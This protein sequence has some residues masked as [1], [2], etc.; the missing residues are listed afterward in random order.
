MKLKKS[1][2]MLTVMLMSILAQFVS[3]IGTIQAFAETVDSEVITEQ[4]PGNLPDVKNTIN[5]AIAN[6]PIDETVLTSDNEDE[7]QTDETIEAETQSEEKKLEERAVEGGRDIT[8]MPNADQL[9][10][11][12]YGEPMILTD[13]DMTLNGK[14]I[15]A[16]D[17]L[18]IGDKFQINY[19]FRIPDEF[20]ATMADGDYF[21]FSLPESDIITLTESQDGDLVDPDNNIVYGKY[22]AETDGSVKMV[23]NAEVSK[24][25]DVDGKLMFSMKID[26]KTIIIPGEHTIEIPGVI[27]TDGLV[28]FIVGQYQSYIEKQYVG[29]EGDTLKWQV[30][31]NPNYLKIDDL[32]LSDFTRIGIKDVAKS[33]NIDG[34]RKVDVDIKGNITEVEKL[35]VS[36]MTVN[37]EGIINTGLNSIDSPYQLDIST[38]LLLGTTG[39]VTNTALL[40][41][42]VGNEEIGQS[43]TAEANAGQELITK[44]AGIYDKKNQTVDWTITYNPKELHIDQKDAFFTDN[45][46]NGTLI[47]DSMTVSPNLSHT[48]K[49][50]ADKKSFDFNFNQDVNEKVIIKYKTKIINSNSK[51]VRNKVIAGEQ[52]ITVEKDISGPGEGEGDGDGEDGDVISTIKKSTPQIIG[53]NGGRW[54]LDIN[55]EKAKLDSWWVEDRV[56]TGSINKGTLQVW[57]ADKSIVPANEYTI[58]WIEEGSVTKGFKLTYKKPTSEHFRIFYSTTLDNRKSQTNQANYHYVVSGKEK[59]DDDSKTLSPPPLGEIGLAKSGHFIP[60]DNEIEWTVVINDNGRVPIQSNHM[61][62]DP[63]KDDQTYVKDSAKVFYKYSSY[64]EENQ[65]SNI[66]FNES[67]NEL[68]VTGLIENDY[69]QKVVFRT[70]LK[71][72]KDILNKTIENTAYYSDDNTP[73]KSATG[74]LEKINNN[75]LFLKKNGTVNSLDPTLIDWKI[76]V[77]PYNQHLKDLEIF[78]DSWENQ[79]IIRESIVLRNPYTNYTMLEGIDYILDYTERGFHIKVK[80]DVTTKL[81]LTYQGRIIFPSG[82]VPG[83]SQQV[84][85]K[86]RMTAKGV[87]TTEN[88]IEVKVPVKVPDSS[89]IIQGK[90]RNLNVRKISEENPNER[91]SGAEFVLYRGTNKDPG[92]VVNR[93]VTDGSGNALFD[94]LTKGDYLLVETQAPSGYS[95][96]S[97]MASGRVV[98]ISD[99]DTTTVEEIVKNPKTGAEKTIEFPVEKKWEKVPSGVETP[100]VTVRLFA[101]GDEKESMLLNSGNK[102]QGT[103]KNLPEKENGKT[104]NYTVK[105]DSIPNYESNINGGVITNTYHNTGKTKFSGK[106]IWEDND[107]EARKRPDKI[108]IILQQDDGK[109]TVEY[110][111]KYAY[112]SDSWAYEFTNLPDINDETGKPFIYSVKEADVP[113][114]YESS[115]VGNNIVNTYQKTEKTSLSGKK[116]W[117]DNN[118]EAKKRPN[119]VT[120]ELYQDGNY[121]QKQEVSSNTDWSY[122]FT[123]LPIYIE[124]TKT[125]HEYK[126]QEVDVPEGYS[127]QV[128]E[129]DI[130]NT[131]T[132]EE[133]E[134]IDISGEKKWDDNYN[135]L[136]TRPKSITIWLMRDNEEEP[137][138]QKILAPAMPNQK[139]KYEFTDL[140]KYAEDG[141]EYRYWIYETEVPGYETYTDGQYNLV[142]YLKND[143][144]INISGKKKWE[145]ENNIDKI[146]P[147]EITV[148]LFR[149]IKEIDTQK[150]SEKTDWKYEFK[151]L[152]KFDDSLK[153]I[154]YTVKEDPIPG[155]TTE[156]IKNGNNIDIKNKHSISEKLNIKGEKF[157]HGDEIYQDE[158]YLKEN[159]LKN[160]RPVSVEIQL[161]RNGQYEKTTYAYATRGWKYE[162]NDLQRYDEN[163]GIYTYEVREKNVPLNYE[164]ETINHDIHN[165]YND[166]ELVDIPFEKIWNDGNYKQLRPNSIDIQLQQMYE[167]S[168]YDKGRRQ[169]VKSGSNGKWEHVFKDLSKYNEDGSL[170]EYRVIEHSWSNDLIGY[171]STSVGINLV[172]TL[173]PKK[174]DISGTKRWDEPKENNLP[175]K[176]LRP[177]EITVNLYQNGVWLE[178]QKVT[179]KNGNGN[180]KWEYQFKNLDKFDPVT[181][182]DYVYTVDEEPVANYAPTYSGTN[183]VNTYNP[184][185]TIDISGEKKWEDQNNGFG[186]PRPIS[187]DVELYQ[188]GVLSDTTTASERTKWQYSFEDLLKFNKETGKEFK[189]TVKE[190][191]VPAGYESKVNKYEITNKYLNTEITEVTGEK[192]WDDYENKFD[193]RPEEVKVVLYQNNHKYKEQMVSGKNNWEYKFTDLKVYD[194]KGQR[195]TYRVEESNVPLGYTSKVSEGKITNTYRPTSKINVSGEKF[196][197]DWDDNHSNDV[198]SRPSEITVELYQNI[199]KSQ[200]QKIKEQKV[201]PDKKGNWRYSFDNLD[202]YDAKGNKYIY[203]VKETPVPGYTQEVKGYDIFNKYIN[204]EKTK[205]SVEKKWTGNSNEPNFRPES[206]EVYLLIDGNKDEKNSAILNEANDWKHTFNDLKK[207]DDNGDLFEYTVIE[208]GIPQYITTY[209]TKDNTVIITNTFDNA[210]NETSISGLKIWDDYNNTHDTRPDSVTIG[211]LQDG[212]PMKDENGNNVTTTTNPG[213]GWQY[214]FS[215]LPLEK[216]P[217]VNYNYSVMEVEPPEFYDAP[218]VDKTNIIN[219]Y[220]NREKIQINGKKTWNDYD[221]KFNTQP[222]SIEITLIK[223]GSPVETV[224]AKKDDKYKFSFN[225]LDK[226]DEQGVAYTYEVVEEVA[227]PYTSEV[228]STI[229]EVNNKIEVE[230]VN[231]YKNT[232]TVDINGEKKWDDYDGKLSTRPNVTIQLYSKTEKNSEPKL[233]ANK[234]VTSADGWKYEFTELPKYDKQG[235][236]LEYFVKEFMLGGTEG[237]TSEIDGFDI[238]NHYV[239]NETVRFKGIKNWIEHNEDAKHRPN[240]I[241]VGLYVDDTKIDETKTDE[242]KN[243]AWEFDKDYPVYDKLGNEIPYQIKENVADYTTSIEESKDSDKRVREYVITNKYI[244]TEKTELSVSKSWDDFNNALTTRPG[245]VKV[246]LF[247]NGNPTTQ[248][249]ELSETNKWQHTFTDLLVYDEDGRKNIYTAQEEEI[250]GYTQIKDGPN[251]INQSEKVTELTH[252]SGEKIWDDENNTL[253]QRPGYITVVLYQNGNPMI[254]ENYQAVSQKVG[255]VTNWKYDFKDLPKYDDEGKE[256]VYSIEELA[257]DKYKTNIIVNSPTEINIVNKYRNTDKIKIDGKKTWDDLDNK[258]LIR[259]ETI[260]IELYQSGRELPYDVKEVKADNNGNWSYMFEDLPKY[261]GQLKEYTYTVKEQSISGYDSKVDG[262]DIKN[263]YRND[264]LTKLEGEK[265]WFDEDDKLGRRPESI[266][267]E[268]HQNGNLML[269]KDGKEVTQTINSEQDG[270]KYSFKDLPVYDDKLDKYTYTVKEKPVDNYTSTIINSNRPA[271]V[272]TI[273]VD[274]KTSVL[275]NK[276]WEDENNKLNKRPNSIQVNLYR[277]NGKIPYRTQKVIPNENGS[278]SYEF[279]NLPKYD[280]KLDL[281]KYTVREMKVPGY[282]GVIVDDHVTNVSTITNTYDNKDETEIKGYK[283]W[284]DQDNKLESRPTSIYVDLYRSDSTDVYQSQK[285]IADD[286]GYWYYSF[287]N[288]PKYDDDLELYEYKVKEQPVHHYDSEVDGFNILNTYRND[289]KTE[290]KG[291]K[292]WV[293]LDDKLNKR[294]ESIEVELYQNNKKIDK[295]TVVEGDDGKW[296]YE[297]TNLPKYD[298]NLKEYKYTVREPKI[299]DY[300]TEVDGTMITNYYQNKEVTKVSGKKVWQDHDDKINSRPATI[301]VDLYQ[302]EGKKPYKTELV[303]SNGTSEWSYEFTDLPKY[304]DKLEEYRYTVKEQKV[305]HYSTEIKDTTITNTY[306]NDR[307]IGIKGEKKWVDF[308]NKLESRPTTIYVDLYQGESKAPMVTEV[309]TPDTNGKWEYEFVNLPEYDENLEKYEYQIKERE[310]PHYNTEI[311]DTTIINTYRNNDKINLS[312]EKKW[313]DFD[314]KLNKRPKAIKVYLYQNDDQ[315][316]IKS[317]NV[318]AD[319][320][321]N[322]NYTFID[323]P[324][325]DDELNEYKYTVKEKTVKDYDSEVEGTTITNTYQNKEVTLI[326][327]EKVWSEDKDDKLKQ[328]PSEITVY[329]HQNGNKEPMKEQ[330]VAPDKNNHWSYEFKDLPKYDEELEPFTY[331]VSEKKVPHYDSEVS[332]TTITNTYR[333]DD[334]TEIM[335]QKIW[336]DEDNELNTRPTSIQID[337]YQNGDKKPFKTQTVT[338]DAKGNWSYAFEELPMY[339]ANLDKYVYT[340]K[341]QDVA[342]YNGKVEGT[343][344]TNTYINDIKTE[345]SGEKT[346]SDKDD[347]LN[348]RPSLIKVDL[349]QNGEKMPGKTEIVKPN[350]SGEWHY[351]FKDLPKY[352]EKLKEFKYTVKEQEVTHYDSKVEGNNIL[353]TYRNDDETEI[354]GEKKWL[355]ENNKIKSRPDSIKV[356]LYQN[357]GEKPFKTQVVEPNKS[358]DWKYTFDKLPKYDANY[359]EYRYTVKEQPVAHYETQING[360]TITN[361]Y[362]NT[363]LTKVEGQKQWNDEGNKLKVRPESIT[364]DLY[365]NGGKK[366]Y[367]TQEVK[368]NTKGEWSYEFKD[369]PKYDK[370][371]NLYEYTVKE[372]AV[373]DYTTVIEGTTIINTYKNVEVTELSGEK[374]WQDFDNKVNSRPGSIMVDLYQNDEKQPFRS[375]KVTPDKNGNWKYTFKA[376][377]KYDEQLNDYQYTV[378]EQTVPHYD[379]QVSG[380]TITN[381]YRNDDKIKFEGKKIWDDADNK[382]NVRPN[383]ITVDLYQNGKKMSG[384]TQEVT[385]DKKGDWTYEFTDLPKYDDQLEAYSYTVKEQPVANYDSKVIGKNITNTYQNNQKTEITGQK[386]WNDNGNKGNTRPDS[387]IVELYQNNGNLPVRKQTVVPDKNGNWHYAFNDLPKHDAALNDY[388]YTVKELPVAGYTSSVNGTTIT[389]TLDS[390]I[391]PP[392][393]KDPKPKIPLVPVDPVS[394]TRRLPWT[395]RETPTSHLPKTGENE[396]NL[397]LLSLVGLS[398]ISMSGMALYFRKRY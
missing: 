341:E 32:T 210:T 93:M 244:N 150:V 275:V 112:A 37:K 227:A 169:T 65:S 256:Y 308:D 397:F 20:G 362:Q 218:K 333:N 380:T 90:T 352:D 391:T 72:P 336:Q 269:D 189:Y 257:V 211:L 91:L 231:T 247:K 152:P 313:N 285:V 34:M 316:P 117:K 202:E 378:K 52:E 168:W 349:Y 226:Y 299:A 166:A 56:D 338:G 212:K 388:Q 108:K 24:N 284:D 120:V 295:K 160:P 137:Y 136:E 294:P 47:E 140:P 359:D 111:D 188:D 270:W 167:G 264:E 3:T 99:S 236:L 134:T 178:S 182:K 151:E 373:D 95:I 143:E 334:K 131:Y 162:F 201:K 276:K 28:I 383:A 214:E 350:K 332:G 180:N 77:N 76:D 149:G 375:Q 234:L 15:T 330:T 258:L 84:T 8:K 11:D 361:T 355:D 23:F 123:D 18:K 26:E 159:D 68:K 147:E 163:G 387:I 155:Y 390:S 354:S 87:Y 239:N 386:F 322:W 342:K 10:K 289:D 250:E 365:Q 156:Y 298:A 328:R 133:V 346:W 12:K 85:N 293:D 296:L 138:D 340:V 73:E 348:V 205:I 146:R 357:E 82:T 177:E 305:P 175:M 165:T 382:L 261:D 198:K 70:K 14:P 385:P 312:G 142:N 343:T 329:L 306:D 30:L 105:E 263:T 393:P 225:D 370:D 7:K 186:G 245:I 230:V 384:K 311:K 102:Y 176:E 197:D 161:F 363:D 297:F 157:W 301:Q 262:Y 80:D 240:E 94:K 396:K 171:E 83:T 86:V 154:T 292:K 398:L 326:K 288:L 252:L 278:W 79:I 187:V 48:V 207:Y 266:T 74:T 40:F 309:V 62:I 237:Y 129:R 203:T 395:G 310:V 291:E 272:N 103:F 325:Y 324:K 360:T 268:L 170:I 243:W 235:D 271:I 69:T 222:D 259:P 110:T 46:E 335:G 61:L 273:V 53:N 223:D 371:L 43:A 233:V 208:E 144:K 141:H 314:N 130:V 181:I 347:K 302:N 220:R 267:V 132:K 39:T 59:E 246:T 394:P 38:P 185:E 228:I 204:D 109:N 323:L 104:V 4:E 58:D 16:V 9:P 89:G 107:D 115:V 121:Y 71:N 97:E 196:W 320:E 25:N 372:K 389:N 55:Q 248:Q 5:E 135:S 63:I 13:A 145:D 127:S 125:K 106:K 217:G 216:S 277:N 286:D 356:D 213:K 317:K 54:T 2:F 353:N 379:S 19:Q 339:D 307:V 78:D 265:I 51:F 164:T 50:S 21:E 49:P 22:Y 81:I 241:T 153:E 200:P 260:K 29:S 118:D 337:L 100:E 45:I 190:K 345:L 67:K 31:I 358:G 319:S 224:E 191:N 44:E 281:Y 374:R 122:K 124:G 88:P 366:A 315:K 318:K 199:E 116:I 367:Q 126:V 392:K 184:T 327:G 287:K 219:K 344:I 96:S 215:N 232:E 195:Y 92:K 282:S 221:N 36:Q 172:N 229:D 27:N 206:I 33:I 238:T 98:T 274:D 57:Y 183:I 6:V 376:L 242:S 66:S 369:L 35:D 119:K 209:Q 255:L 64:W 179:E 114:G 351:T 254:D 253:Q 60:E 42:K 303:K 304:D 1:V 101:N 128:I 377:P 17:P 75:D 331:T 300:K 249:V 364:V 192:V 251:F 113:N 41:G 173:K 381:T 290:V 279:T 283:A 148:R 139:W 174:I 321:G 368:A 280:K 194:D 158:E 193:T